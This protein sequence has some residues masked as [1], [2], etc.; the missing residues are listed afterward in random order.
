MLR[1]EPYIKNA[2]HVIWDWNGTLLSDLQH[3]INTVNHFLVARNLPSLSQEQYKKVFGFPIRSYYETIGFD[4]SKESFEDL[5]RDFVDRYMG[6]V[7]SCELHQDAKSLL[8][9]VK[10]S[11]KTQ[12]I[13][14]AS[15]QESLSRM[16]DHYGIG[17]FLD[18]VYGIADK[19]AASKVHR[20][21]ELI[22]H[23]K[24]DPKATIL[25]GDTDHDLEVG[26]E[27]GVEVILLAH[28][29]QCAEKLRKIHH[30]VVELI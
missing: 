15:D 9:Q 19:L 30:S 20:G 4:L 25:F 26:R 27:L 23:S 29:H 7:F 5:C 8:K 22:D 10:D 3:T 21:R 14:S 13:L 16:V 24:I 11:G 18:N 1:L 28:G 17:D 6:G 12:S 2:K